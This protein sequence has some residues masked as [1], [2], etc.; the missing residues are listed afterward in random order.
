MPLPAEN[1]KSMLLPKIGYRNVPKFSDRQVWANSADPDKTA[2][3]LI[4][5]Y[6]VCNFLCIFWM[7]YSKEKPSCSTFRV[8]TANFRVSE[9]L[10]FLQYI[11]IPASASEHFV[12]QGMWVSDVVGI[13]MCMDCFD[14]KIIRLGTMADLAI[15][16]RSIYNSHF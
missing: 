8:I 2:P 10:V 4:R 9:I 16:V 1:D 11:R 6:T 13:V 15:I 14:H 3:S 12:I 5:V 7:H